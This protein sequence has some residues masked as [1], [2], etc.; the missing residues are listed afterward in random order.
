MAWL[1]AILILAFLIGALLFL[2]VGGS[3][4]KAIFSDAHLIELSGALHRVRAAA[5]ER[6]EPANAVFAVAP[7]AADAVRTDPR[8]E[9]TSAG[10]RVL[11]SITELSDEPDYLSHHV[12]LSHP[13]GLLAESG[14]RFL[15]AFVLD[16]FSLP[17]D[18]A[19]VRRSQNLV[20]HLMFGVAREHHDGFVATQMPT[21]LM[22]DLPSLRSRVGDGVQLV[23]FDLLKG[24]QPE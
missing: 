10:L 21:L 4:W 18:A 23:N 20:I 12:S 5:A 16:Q 15:A 11:Y 22:E 19:T 2:R 17:P 9:V 3:P 14:S 1:G 13:D 24:R 8:S 7:A 6:V